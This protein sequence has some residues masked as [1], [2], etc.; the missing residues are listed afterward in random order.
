MSIYLHLSTFKHIQVFMFLFNYHFT[1][2]WFNFIEAL[3]IYCI[4]VCWMFYLPKEDNWWWKLGSFR[5]A[6]FSEGNP[7]A[8]KARLV[9]LVIYFNAPGNHGLKCY[10]YFNL[11]IIL[12]V[13]HLYFGICFLATLYQCELFAIHPN[14][15]FLLL[16]T[17]YHSKPFEI[18]PHH[19]LSIFI[20]L[21][22]SLSLPL[23]PPLCFWAHTF[24]SFLSIKKPSSAFYLLS[25]SVPLPLPPS[26]PTSLFLSLSLSLSLSLPLSLS[27][28]PSRVCV[29]TCLHVQ[30]CHYLYICLHTCV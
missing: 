4:S 21:Y 30:T 8:S 27:L 16:N 10:L 7:I 2:L 18:N 12:S 11:C 20:A 19:S 9:S 29:C 28:S 17:F 5:N 22:L 3:F 26:L 25:N 23:S 6:I 24:I 14:I 15:L 13:Y 1:P